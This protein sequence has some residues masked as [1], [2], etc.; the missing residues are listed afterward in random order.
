[1]PLAYQT[2]YVLWNTILSF[3]QLE[4][5]MDRLA[6]LH[7]DRS[8]P[9]ENKSWLTASSVYS[10]INSTDWIGVKWDHWWL[11]KRTYKS[12]KKAESP[13]SSDN[14]IRR[15]L[16]FCYTRSIFDEQTSSYGWKKK[17]K[18]TVANSEYEKGCAE[19]T[20]IRRIAW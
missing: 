5:L 19:I 6:V 13:S 16:F 18:S 7:N 14:G 9:K 2:H 1:M 11:I 3:G 15:F 4:K 10:T 20:A 8:I 12:N 17:K